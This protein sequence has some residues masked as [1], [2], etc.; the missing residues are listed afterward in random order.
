MPL[1]YNISKVFQRGKASHKHSGDLLGEGE[2]Q[3]SEGR[4]YHGPGRDPLKRPEDHCQHDVRHTRG[5]ATQ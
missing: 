1:A 2:A 4:G 5:P 3:D